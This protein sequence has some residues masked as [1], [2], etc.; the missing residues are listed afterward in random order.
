MGCRRKT[1]LYLDRSKLSYLGWLVSDSVK[2]S[3]YCRRISW[4]LLSNTEEVWGVQLIIW[5]LGESWLCDLVDR[6]QVLQIRTSWARS[7]C[8]Y[9][10]TTQTVWWYSV[11]QFSRSDTASTFLWFLSVAIVHQ[12]AFTF[13]FLYSVNFLRSSLF[14]LKWYG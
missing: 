10:K 11:G 1:R 13:L 5:L 3:D 14:C 6:S 8:R 4:T 12:I 7:I 2:V 9:M